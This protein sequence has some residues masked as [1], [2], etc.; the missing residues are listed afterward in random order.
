MDDEDLRLM[1]QSAPR[2][3][4]PEVAPAA[5]L[6]VMQEAEDAWDAAAPGPE[7]GE[8]LERLEAQICSMAGNL[9]ASTC[10]WLI[11]LGEFARRSGWA[12]WGMKS[13]A[14]W[15][16]WSCSVT[17]VAA[18]EY[19]RVAVAL[20]SLPLIRG[21]FAEG[22]LSY[23]KVRAVTRV[24]DR[25][26]EQVL[27]DQALVHTASQLERTISGY[28]KAEGSASSQHR[29]RRA[30]WFY[31][32]D[33]MLVLT[34]RLP[35]E[36]GAVVVAALEQARHD[37]LIADAPPVDPPPVDTPPVDTGDADRSRTDAA[38]ALVLVAERALA[39]G[40][41]DRSGDDRHLVVLHVDAGVLAAAN[42]SSPES[43]VQPES[44]QP[45][46][47]PPAHTCQPGPNG[48]GECCRIEDGP[49]LEPATALRIACDAA[50][51]PVVN[52]ALPWE[53][54][55][56]G[57]GTRAISKALRRALRVR[58]GGCCFPGCTRRGYLEAHHVQH[59][60]HGGPTDLENL[61]LFCR[62]D[63]M[64]V[65][66]DG[67]T[68]EPA[69][70]STVPVP[71]DVHWVF[72]RPDGTPLPAVPELHPD[73]HPDRPDQDPCDPTAIR[74]GWCGERFSLVDSVDVLVRST[75]DAAG[76]SDAVAS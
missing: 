51:L 41:V 43:P 52:A 13:C 24:A 57:R 7:T 73:D 30:R 34:A 32:E 45:V 68:V 2:R 70:T 1:W 56:L 63:H 10:A 58:D 8:P 22:R 4:D 26:D 16:S 55:R 21:A 38:D 6:P 65:H 27:L 37:Q 33:G 17:P 3:R 53:Q 15:L 18:R 61:L 14:H 5:M 50:I 49:G 36:Q 60:A 75:F 40:P 69:A 71:A 44:I 39:S 76:A 47:D 54:L 42:P 48:L 29:R 28:R 72:R 62:K 59:W 25:I 12:Q 66:E 46:A 11:L 31:D 64:R 74:P 35:A 23:S 19:V 67:Y 20:E 9:A